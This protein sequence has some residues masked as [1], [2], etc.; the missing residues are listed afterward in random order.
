MKNYEGIFGHRGGRYDAAMRAYPR[1]RD[2]EFSQL[3]AR[4]G[5]KAG[6]VVVDVP[7]GGGYLRHYLPEHCD[8]W[9][10]E[11][12]PSFLGSH[13]EEPDAGL[14]PL[15]WSEGSVDAAVSLAGV[16][17]TRDK[18]PFFSA[19]HEV[20]K[21][22]GRF[23]LSDVAEGSSVALFLDEYVGAYNSTGH[24]GFYLNEQTL[25]ELEACGWSVSSY[26]QV[27]FHWIFSDRRA[28]ADFCTQ[29]FDLVCSLDVTSAAI[30]HRLGVDCVLG[31]QVGMRWSLMT[32]VAQR[33]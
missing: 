21:P 14:L 32:V 16:H 29:L 15:P 23:V 26:E 25:L 19:L 20:V 18:R 7:A 31:Q 9:G 2:Q 8:W 13:I 33:S 5:P 28:M 4:L 22:R 6:E 24:E 12:C 11:P 10:H 30:E 3:I 27:D 17:H 1:A